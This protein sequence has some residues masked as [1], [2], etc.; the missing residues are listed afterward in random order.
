M[1]PRLFAI[2]MDLDLLSP[3]HA[4]QAE[5]PEDCLEF[6]RS[7]CTE[8]AAARSLSLKQ[9]LDSICRRELSGDESQ[10]LAS[11]G[12]INMFSIVSAVH[13]VIFQLSQTSFGFQPNFEPI[14][15][16]LQN[17][18]QIWQRIP[19]LSF[20]TY[21]SLASAHD[22]NDVTKLWKRNG[23]CKHSAEY[24]HFAELMLEYVSTVHSQAAA[25]PSLG[26]RIIEKYD[27]DYHQVNALMSQ[28]QD[29]RLGQVVSG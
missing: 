1:P 4:F 14:R 5:T 11:M 15:N 25:G 26:H 8:A 17:W 22:P 23:F 28:L 29:M 18:K 12:V 7:W 3:E 9:A 10:Q 19:T 6:L 21:E 20:S 24:W 13:S 16:A 27:Q 2:E